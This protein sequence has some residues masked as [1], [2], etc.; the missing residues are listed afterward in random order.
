MKKQSQPRKTKNTIT[1]DGKKHYK[2]WT[3]LEPEVATIDI[4][5]EYAERN[6]VKIKRAF[7]E[8]IR[9]AG[10]DDVR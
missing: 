3:V 8:M 5:R 1:I 7:S 10:D 6:N 4:I 2:R 9:K